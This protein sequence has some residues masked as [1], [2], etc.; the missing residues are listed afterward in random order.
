[1][2][3]SSVINLLNNTIAL[4]DAVL[5]D[6]EKRSLHPPTVEFFRGQKIIAERVLAMLEGQPEPE[7][8]LRGEIVKGVLKIYDAEGNLIDGTILTQGESG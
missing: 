6:A 1:M 8:M 4:A 7:I 5:L 2:T 3:N